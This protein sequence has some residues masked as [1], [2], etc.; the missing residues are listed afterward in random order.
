MNEDTLVSIEKKM[1]VLIKLIAGNLVK[2]KT[3]TD[4]IITLGN[5]GIEVGT[6]ANLVGTTTN[7][8]SVTLSNNKKKQ[9]SKKKTTKGKEE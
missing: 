2:D 4:A 1:D 9:S 7:F 3:K 8:V 5:C 6:I